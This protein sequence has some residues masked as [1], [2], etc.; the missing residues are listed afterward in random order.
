M[1]WM[2]GIAASA[3]RVRQRDECGLGE[4]RR[5]ERGLDGQQHG[6]CGLRGLDGRRRGEHGI[7]GL[8]GRRRNERGLRGWTDGGTASAACA[9]YMVFRLSI[10]RMRSRS[11]CKRIS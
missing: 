3:A 11:T 4:Q 1:A 10:T 7:H 9:A 5:S 6:G 2:N 8:G